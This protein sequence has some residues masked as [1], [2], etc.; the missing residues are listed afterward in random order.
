MQDVSH[1][2]D[3]W[4]RQIAS[5]WPAL[6]GSLAKVYKPCIRKNC[7]ACARGDKHPAWLLSL[8]HQGRR[9]TRYV[10]AHLVPTIQKAIKNGRR[11]EELLYRAGP[12]LLQHYRQSPKTLRSQPPKS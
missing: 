7:P 1:A 9:T 2:R 11:L 10:P 4:L 8:S 5:L 12:Q 6:K 3:R